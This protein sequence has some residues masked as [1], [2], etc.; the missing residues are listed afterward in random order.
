MSNDTFSVG[1]LTD[2]RE[3]DAE[4]P[5]LEEAERAASQAAM[6]TDKVFGVWGPFDDGG[7]LLAVAY[8]ADLF[9]K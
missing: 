4:F 3:T 6:M 7:E 2:P 8:G 9:T 1:E 5:T